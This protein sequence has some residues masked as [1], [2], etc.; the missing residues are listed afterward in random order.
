MATE[1]TTQTAALAAARRKELT[2]SMIELAGMLPVLLAGKTK[3][4][5]ALD[6]IS[7][8]GGT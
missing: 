1:A 4:K 7:G 6:D 8:A 5:E 2:R 3:P